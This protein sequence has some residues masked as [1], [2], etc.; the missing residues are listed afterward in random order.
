VEQDDLDPATESA[1]APDAT[2]VGRSFVVYPE[3]GLLSRPLWRAIG[4]EV[5]ARLLAPGDRKLLDASRLVGRVDE[6]LYVGLPGRAAATRAESR[7]APPLARAA[8]AILER[9]VELRFVSFADW[10]IA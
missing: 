6:V 3:L 5:R 2:S 7:L 4:D 9:P 10:P 1:T 8:R